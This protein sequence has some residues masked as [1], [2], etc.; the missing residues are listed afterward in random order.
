MEQHEGYILV[1][2]SE[3]LTGVGYE[4]LVDGYCF[5]YHLNGLLH[6]D[7]DK[8]S[9]ED[10]NG[11]K[12]WY[13]NGVLHRALGPAV[14]TTLIDDTMEEY[15]LRGKEIVDK[16]REDFIQM[17]GADISEVPLYINH[18]VLSEIARERLIMVSQDD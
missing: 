11:T 8:P 10:F 3:D 6:R 15:Y 1:T 14:I 18:P 17:V 13:K 4:A 2:S 16:D 9:Y 7:D 5:S 12:K